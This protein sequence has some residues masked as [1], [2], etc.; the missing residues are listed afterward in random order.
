MKNK[1][2]FQWLLASVALFLSLSARAQTT[3]VQDRVVYMSEYY[4]NMLMYNPA[5]TG[6]LSQ[7]NVGFSNRFGKETADI[8]PLTFNF[9][10]HTKSFDL[11]SGFGIKAHY[12]KFDDKFI[13]QQNAGEKTDKRIIEI[14]G[15]YSYEM[16]LFEIASV[17]IATNVSALHYQS[18]ARNFNNPTGTVSQVQNERFFKMNIDLGLL[19]K[20]QDFRFGMSVVNSNE[21][22]FTFTSSGFDTKT[23]RRQVY[24]NTSYKFG[25]NDMIYIEPNIMMHSYTGTTARNLKPLLDFSLLLRYKN[26]FYAGTSYKLNNAPYNMSLMF[27]G[28]FN[29]IQVSAAYNLVGKKYDSSNYS[30]IELMLAFYLQSEE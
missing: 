6:D 3:T 12:H 21:P 14:G 16:P 10:A 27:G 30:R 17:A 25:I 28:R 19:F 5:Y 1:N 8:K 4:N 26:H 20:M 22:T 29:S 24:L 23:F 9:F 2:T 11:N 13:N 15:L 18:K 7:A